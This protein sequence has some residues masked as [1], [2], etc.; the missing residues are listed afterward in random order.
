MLTLSW[1]HTRLFFKD[2]ASVFFSFLSVFIVIILYLL[3]LSDNLASSLPD[4]PARMQF[5]FLWMF[6]GII[7]VTT[8]TT[9]LGALGKFTEDKVNLV[10]EDFLMAPITTKQLAYSYIYYALGIALFFTLILTLFGY[11]YTF[12]TFDYSFKLTGKLIG[13]IFLASLLHTLIFY[14]I[15]THIKS[16]SAFSGLATIVGT[17]IGFLAGI[18]IPIGLLPAYLQ[19]IMIL[20]PT[21][22]IN[23]LLKD[24]LMVDLLVDIKS[25]LKP[26][27]Y[28]ELVT[29]LGIRFD[30]NSSLLPLSYSWTYL[31]ATVS[32]LIFILYLRHLK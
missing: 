29:G 7:A 31:F 15:V 16:L 8:A 1:R 23:L 17:L 19:K 24:T 14:L 6:S 25:N 27:H 21:T 11:F 3:F 2:K 13:L 10:Q 5:V 12:Y 22:H 26:E 18:Y 28:T 32:V 20:I 4:F 30:W 9:S